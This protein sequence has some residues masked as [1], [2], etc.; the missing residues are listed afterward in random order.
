MFNAVIYGVALA[1]LWY[2]LY[3]IVRKDFS[4]QT[5]KRWVAVI[6]PQGVVVAIAL[7]LLGIL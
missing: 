4:S 2:W 6:V 3:L 1:S 7:V 5:L